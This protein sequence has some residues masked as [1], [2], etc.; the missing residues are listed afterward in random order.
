MYELVIFGNPIA[1][2]RPRVTRWSTYYK[3]PYNSYKS[4]LRAKVVESIANSNFTP[5][6]ASLPLKMYITFEMEIPKSFST[7]KRL[8][9]EGT[10]VVKKPD[11]DNLS[12]SCFDAMNKIVYN[13]DSQIVE[14][15]VKKVYS[16][17][18]KTII[19][20]EEIR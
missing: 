19:K 18:P 7:K 15:I 10:Y 1:A 3:E 12:K 14:I 8:S 17:E 11:I 4:F 6:D 20:I 5:F 9:L 13:D 16:F 2:S